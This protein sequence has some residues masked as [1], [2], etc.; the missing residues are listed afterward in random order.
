M[1]TEEKS[2]IDARMTQTLDYLDSI[3]DESYNAL[4]AKLFIQ[5]LA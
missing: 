1:F 2:K 5:D 4:K 3:K